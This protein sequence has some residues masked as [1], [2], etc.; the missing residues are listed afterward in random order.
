MQSHGSVFH[1]E[2]IFMTNHLATLASLNYLEFS[3]AVQASMLQLHGMASLLGLHS[4]TPMIHAWPQS[5]SF[6]RHRG[7]FP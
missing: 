5:V 2:K 3:K 4:G 7:K 1:V 6:F